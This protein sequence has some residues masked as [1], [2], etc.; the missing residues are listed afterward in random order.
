MGGAAWP[1]LLGGLLCLVDSRNKRDL[2]LVNGVKYYSSLISS[3]RDIED[4][5]YSHSFLISANYLTY[6]VAVVISCMSDDMYRNTV[7]IVVNSVQT[8]SVLSSLS[9]FFVHVYL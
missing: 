3:L 2:S 6:A 8:S 4:N 1:F 5:L 7:V 9:V